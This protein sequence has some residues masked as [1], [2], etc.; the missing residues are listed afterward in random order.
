MSRS[1]RKSPVTG[2]TTSESEKDD[3][4][5]YNRRYRRASK[6][7]FEND[8]VRDPMPKLREFSDPWLMDKDGKARFDPSEY[9]EL[10]R[11]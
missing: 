4:R 7:L 11:K 3:K 2:I 1:R 6:Q 10:M 5:I 8:P 9:P